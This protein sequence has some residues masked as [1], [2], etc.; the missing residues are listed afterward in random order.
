MFC[1]VVLN[2]LFYLTEETK[3]VPW[4]PVLC[5]FLTLIWGGMWPGIVTFPNCTC[6]V[7]SGIFGRTA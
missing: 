4:M 2:M 5:L 7:K 3:A 6:R 1:D